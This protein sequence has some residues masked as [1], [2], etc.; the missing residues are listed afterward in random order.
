MILD[1][2]ENTPSERE[3]LRGGKVP[4]V[5]QDEGDSSVSQ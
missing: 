2:D 5:R 3:V 4:E 1:L